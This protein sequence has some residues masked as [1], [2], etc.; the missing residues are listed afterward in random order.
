[1][2]ADAGV[3]PSY[4]QQSSVCPLFPLQLSSDGGK[5]QKPSAAL[6]VLCLRCADAYLIFWKREAFKLSI[7]T[8]LAFPHISRLSTFRHSRWESGS[9]F[10]RLW[11]TLW[12]KE[13]LQVTDAAKQRERRFQLW[14][15]VCSQCRFTLKGGVLAG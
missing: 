8:T 10:Q 14:W 7:M 12:V 6:P 9:I 11:T 2:L 1:M 13:L 5:P 4:C 3:A 15:R